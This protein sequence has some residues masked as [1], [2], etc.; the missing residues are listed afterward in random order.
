M[1]LVDLIC[2]EC[3]V[4]QID[5]GEQKVFDGTS[6][7]TQFE[8]INNN[9]IYE[10]NCSRGHTS[11]T[12][13]DNINFEILF[14]YGLN[15]IAD[16][17]YREA[18]SSLTAAMER[19]FEFFIKTV[20]KVTKTDF[21]SIESAWKKVSNQT[22]RQFGGY[23]FLYYHVFGKE[24]IL[25]NPNKDIAFRN[26]VIH[27]GYIPTEKE[28]IKYG[29]SILKLIENSLINLKRK[30]PLETKQTFIQYGYKKAAN[31]MF[32]K[33]EK[34]S[35]VEQKIAIVNIMTTIDVVNGRELNS[36]D[37]RNG[38]VEDRVKSILRMREPR[39]LILQKGKTQQ[40]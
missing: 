25:L 5:K 11:K 33:I 32:L 28:A 31:E 27:K 7:P 12:I 30:F 21:S 19:Y 3:L 9:G 35:G 18:V 37:G 34:E 36:N 39:R 8:Q 20:L 22:E 13:I 6:I 15:A 4:E 10:V 40:K 26:S 38:F 17:Y 1:M 29:N 16:G 23:L 2:Y 24:P 14:E